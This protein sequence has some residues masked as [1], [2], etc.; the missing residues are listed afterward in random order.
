MKLH[1]IKVP[2]Q[3]SAP[4]ALYVLVAV[5]GML[6]LFSGCASNDPAD[7]GPSPEEQLAELQQQYRELES[8]YASLEIR[9]ANLQTAL[10]GAEAEA[11][12][13]R[14]SDEQSE[15]AI[16]ALES[17]LAEAR[18]QIRLLSDALNEARFAEQLF[19]AV[20][21]AD[22]T[23][24]EESSDDADG[25]TRQ[26]PESLDPREASDTGDAFE[27]E[28]YL[29]EDSVFSASAIGRSEGELLGGSNLISQQASDN[30]LYISH[31]DSGHFNAEE[32][33]LEIEQAP[34]RGLVLYL[35]LQS[36]TAS[37]EDPI[38]LYG[39]DLSL[40]GSFVISPP[41][42]SRVERLADPVRVL[43]RAY[44]PL[45]PPS[46]QALGRMVI[47][48]RGKIVI[49]GLYGEREYLID[50]ERAMIMQEVISAFLEISP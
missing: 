47:E 29:P 9:L 30:T 36:I 15:G 23:P 32:A 11:N 49:K 28:R 12:I 34:D 16:A 6:L 4:G 39:A 40:A 24:D 22:P 50:P 48:K 38:G 42:A 33:Y 14:Q 26:S 41:Q 25:D 46:L 17:D 37:G 35:V 13:A 31:R 21:P 1:N 7:E 44:L 3:L 2:P 10:E 5:A 19:T 18:D 20:P 27:T 45:D 8:E 43:E